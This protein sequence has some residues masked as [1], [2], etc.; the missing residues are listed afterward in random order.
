MDEISAASHEQA[1]GIEQ[2]NKAV[3]E[4][5]AV[6]QQNA[7]HAEESASAAEELTAQA[8]HMREFAGALRA[9]VDSSKGNGTAR[10]TASVDNKTLKNKATEN[11][12]RFFAGHQNKGNGH[13]TKDNG[14]TFTQF[15]KGETRP[16]RLIPFDVS[17]F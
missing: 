1:Q 4:M 10:S 3:N 15:R 11:P 8:E 5:D 7:A 16:E 14:K 12:P 9:L 2:I 13:F 6:V 17:D